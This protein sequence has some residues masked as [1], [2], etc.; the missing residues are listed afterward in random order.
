MLRYISSI[1][2]LVLCSSTFGFECDFVNGRTFYTPGDSDF[3]YK[4]VFSKDG[5]LKISIFTISHETKNEKLEKSIYKGKFKVEKDQLKAEFKL[6]KTK[7]E[8][9]YS[10]VDKEQY[11]AAGPFSKS[12]KPV[13][14]NPSNHSFSFLSFWP[15]GSP[16][17]RKI[18]EK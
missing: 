1:Y 4:Y 2:L 12:L 8:I 10:C 11:M 9:T 16:V 7:Y 14:S 3:Q 18:F 17:I 6:D 13:Q 15:K 5:T